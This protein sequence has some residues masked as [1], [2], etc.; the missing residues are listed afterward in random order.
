MWHE[1]IIFSLVDGEGVAFFYKDIL[2]II[3]IFSSHKAYK[4]LVDDKGVVKI[5]SYEVLTY[6]N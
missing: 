5:L 6:K 3:T 2:V 1:S 4:A